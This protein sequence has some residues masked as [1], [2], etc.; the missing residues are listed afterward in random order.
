MYKYSLY[1]NHT[2]HDCL[3]KKQ[4]LDFNNFYL[5]KP[6]LILEFLFNVTR[7]RRKKR[8]LNLVDTAKNHYGRSL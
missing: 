7:S 8:T 5:P 1:Q 6:S 3:V 4:T 2:L